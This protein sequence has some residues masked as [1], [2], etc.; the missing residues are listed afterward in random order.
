MRLLDKPLYTVP[1]LLLLLA[2][3]SACGRTSSVGGGAGVDSGSEPRDLASKLDL[4]SEPDLAP[5]DLGPETVVHLDLEVPAVDLAQTDLAQTPN[6]FSAAPPDAAFA[7]LSEPVDLATPSDLV[8]NTVDLAAVDLSYPTTCGVA[9][10]TPP[11]LLMH[12][13]VISSSCPQPDN[14]R[15]ADL[16]GDGISEMIVTCRGNFG[17][18]IGI[19]N[20]S[21]PDIVV[22]HDE[23]LVV[24]HYGLGHLDNDAAIDI[25]LVTND[26]RLIVEHGDGLGGFTAR[27]AYD[28]VISNASDLALADFDNDGNT[29][30]YVTMTTNTVRFFKGSSSGVLTAG[31][32]AMGA[33][34]APTVVDLDADGVP[35]VVARYGGFFAVDRSL[36]DGTFSRYIGSIGG[37]NTSS[38]TTGDFDEDG[39][40]DVVMNGKML[41]GTGSG[42][43]YFATAIDLPS[44]PETLLAYDVDQD[45]H[46]DLVTRGAMT[47]L[48]GTGQG[49][50]VAGPSLGVQ[51]TSAIV[52]DQ[53]SD[54]VPDLVVVDDFGPIHGSR[55]VIEGKVGG[56]LDVASSYV[57]APQER[58]LDIDGDG[59]ADAVSIAYG[60]A[61]LSVV[62]K[63]G[64][65]GPVLAPAQTF[66]TGLPGALRAI[67]F[68]DLNGDARQDIVALID[69]GTYRLAASLQQANGTFGTAHYSSA[70]LVN[71]TIACKDLSGDGKADVVK[72]SASRSDALFFLGAGDGS[73]A[74]AS[75]H[76]LG[77]YPL[78]VAVADVNGDGRYDVLS[79]D[80]NFLS[81]VLGRPDGQFFAPI[82][83]ERFSFAGAGTLVMFTAD[84]DGDGRIDVALANGAG[85]GV[86]YLFHGFGNGAFAR[87]MD[88]I[89][90]I[91]ASFAADLNED[92]LVDLGG[93]NGGVSLYLG[94]K[95]TC[96]AAPT[97]YSMGMCGSQ[98]PDAGD[99]DGDGHVD[100][101]C[102]AS[103]P[104]SPRFMIATNAHP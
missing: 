25:A 96:V 40:P 41:R 6:D 15:A 55:I 2:T 45:G 17:A 76:P 16:D 94:A 60:S 88:P 61:T 63:L 62:V 67:T 43:P 30:V 72:V 51:G 54:G 37:V 46:L 35:D 70:G 64:G 95:N 58:A 56:G 78:V 44:T 81:T 22:R 29:D 7:D 73:F 57:D 23:D 84:F 11:P 89:L 85:P 91:P 1:W 38:L 100:I 31:G 99:F 27:E 13:P 80:G 97:T 82:V 3:V 59:F 103:I 24:T 26:G 28:A 42:P 4:A 39:I 10:P 19:A 102:P 104:L 75:S 86:T 21:S 53:T 5:L 74:P 90:P 9:T 12:A 52:L 68:C 32:L 71:E 49:T 33:V 92:G 83:G 66:A 34:Y 48:F 87:P 69:D 101:I 14:L 93:W 20:G 98:F 18:G 47:V 77:L 65:P 50:F 79:S 36:G 8:H